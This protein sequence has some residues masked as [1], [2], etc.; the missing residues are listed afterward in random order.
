MQ[1]DIRSDECHCTHAAEN[2]MHHR[3]ASGQNIQKWACKGSSGLTLDIYEGEIFELIGPTVRQV[4]FD[5]V[6]FGML[7]LIPAASQ[8]WVCTRLSLDEEGWTG[9]APSVPTSKMDVGAAVL[10]ITICLPGASPVR[11]TRKSTTADQSGRYRPMFGT[12]ESHI[13]PRHVATLNIAQMLL[14][15]PRLLLLDE[16]TLGLRSTREWCRC[17]KF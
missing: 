2:E 12:G 17:E 4:D 7:S 11:V 1:T 3:A 13:F 8:S 6:L 10:N 14:G 9:Y 15:E 5:G 16:P